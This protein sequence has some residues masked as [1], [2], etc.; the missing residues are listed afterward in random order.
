[1]S[2]SPVVPVREGEVL[3]G[4][5]RVEQVLGVG[6]MGVVV[7]AHHLQLDEKVAMKFLLPEALGNRD[8]VGRFTR[9]ARAAIKIKSEHVAR[10]LDVGVLDTGAPYIVMEY[11]EGANL[12][13]LLRERGVFDVEVA[14]DFVLQ[15]L[16]AVAEAHAL[17]IVHRD[18][19]P[20]N[21]FCI[22]RS[23]GVLAVKVLDFGISKFESRALS[24]DDMSMS[25]TSNVM[26]SPL[27]MSPEQLRAARDVDARADI[28][29]IGVILYE[30]L[31]GKVPFHASSFPELCVTILSSQPR[32]MHAIRQDVPPGLERVILRCLEKDRAQRYA[33]VAD[34][35]RALGEFGPA[36]CVASVE[37]IGRVIR[38]SQRAGG[39][40]AHARAV[41]PQRSDHLV[42]PAYRTVPAVTWGNTGR[43]NRGR[44]AV[45]TAVAVL[46]LIGG[47]GAILWRGRIGTNSGSAA[48][49]TSVTVMVTPPARVPATAA[50]RE[51]VPFE[52]LVVGAARDAGPAPRTVIAAPQVTERPAS[53]AIPVTRPE[54][55]QISVHDAPSA[56]AAASSLPSSAPPAPMPPLP[57][58][59]DPW[60]APREK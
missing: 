31:T 50:S 14:V 47:V 18:L 3:A 40:G 51:A 2:S 9:E 17:G 29:A 1:M 45:V 6:G 42:E 32:A 57:E 35:A 52:P 5:Y 28:W 33:N 43:G 48:P 15:A 19:K 53:S 49:S 38:A 46:A 8:A 12:T 60:A 21:L 58:I 26:G 30:L 4:K 54:R 56:T 23:D 59:V 37:R 39:D 41:A 22:R 55:K 7:A 13:T 20:A 10:V 34:L 44:T 11:L 27:Y 16:E 24:A 25:H 36:R